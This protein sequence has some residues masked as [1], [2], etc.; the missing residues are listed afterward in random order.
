MTSLPAGVTVY[1]EIKPGYDSI[2]THDALKFVSELH[3]KFEPTRQYLLCERVK[4][5]NLIDAGENLK[6]AVGNHDD[7]WKVAPVPADLQCRH[8]EITGPVERK[9]IIN[10]LNSGADVFMADFEDSLSP[11]WNNIIEGHINLRDANLKTIEFLNPDGSTRKLKEK[12]AQLLVRTRGWHLDEKHVHVDGKPV[13]GG[14]IDF[15]LYFFHNIHNRLEN[16]SSTYFY[17]PKMEHHLECRLWN[18]IFEFSEKY[19]CIPTGKIRATIMVETFPAA[20]EMEEMLYELRNYACGMNAGRWDYIFSIIKTL[21]S[22][23]DCIMPDRKQVTMQVPFMRSYAERLVQICH[24]HGAH[25]M[26]GMSAFIPSRRYEEINK[27]AISQVT[28]DKEREVEEGYDGTWV[29]HPDLVKLAKDIFMKGL[30]AKDNQ[31]ERAPFDKIITENDLS[32]I[33]IDGGKVTEEGVRVNVSIGLQYLNSWFRGH[34]AAAINNLMEDAA[35]A[36]ISRAQLWQ[37]LH[38]S[39]KLDDGRTLT[40]ALF[41]TVLS[42]EVEKLGGRENESFF[43]AAEIVEKLVV[44]NDFETF[45]TIPGYDCLVG[46]LKR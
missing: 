41:K 2:L 26:G 9:M 40:E 24:K 15:A 20:Y 36:E 38:H 28:I 45:L 32:T 12:I 7:K 3:K 46:S 33:V 16:N 23:D 11:T 5:Q 35:T 44:S 13:S 43:S 1:G 10:A 14:L 30:N 6:F 42:E 8:C 22:R 29:A 4:R 17:L 39:T 31:K 27:T 18:D 34:G 25:A 21:K 37:W 19:L